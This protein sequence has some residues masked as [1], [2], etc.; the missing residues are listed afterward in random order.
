MDN[1]G[2]TPDAEISQKPIPLKYKTLTYLVWI[3]LIYFALT[4]IQ[5]SVGNLQA[6]SFDLVAYISLGFFLAWIQWEG[7]MQKKIGNEIFIEYYPPIKIKALFMSMVLFCLLALEFWLRWEKIINP[8]IMI[9]LPSVLI[10]G[11][12]LILRIVLYEKKYGKLFMVRT[13]SPPKIILPE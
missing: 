3:A 2:M 11:L 5:Y 9:I 10:A 12:F 13:T 4:V 6:D 7:W 8:L 1:D